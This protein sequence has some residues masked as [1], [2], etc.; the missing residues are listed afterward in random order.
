M[1]CA[2]EK[3]TFVFLDFH[4]LIFIFVEKHS[5]FKRSRFIQLKMKRTKQIIKG[6]IIIYTLG[7]FSYLIPKKKNSYAFVSFF[8]RKKFSGNLKSFLL[9]VHESHPEIETTYVGNNKDVVKEVEEHNIKTASRPLS[10]FWTVLRAEHVFIDASTFFFSVGR[11]SV[12]QLWH[13]TGFKNIALLNRNTKNIIR[14]YFKKATRKYRIVVC[15]SESDCKK[16][17]KSFETE[18]VV[19]TGLPRNDELFVDEKVE[20]E[21]LEKYKLE[22]YDKIITYAPTWRDFPT[23]Q[24]FSEEFWRKLNNYLV[25]N[26]SFFL[27]VKHPYSSFL[28]IPTAYSNIGDYTKVINDIQEILVVTDFLITDYS[29]VITDYAIM[30]KP[31]LIYAYDL[32]L[33]IENCRSFGYDLK[34]VLPN[35]ILKTEDELLEKLIDTSWKNSPEVIEEHEEFKN[36]FHKYCDGNSCERVMEEVLSL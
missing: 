27:V 29:S 32:E 21:L 18:N 15:T 20:N 33:Y 13:G 6:T 34:E 14:Y 5:H 28:K 8:D 12:V 35:P 1:F 19:A 7:F 2:C 10:L 30:D 23:K 31:F 17:G 25:Q 36:M 24:P 22:R 9:Y 16:K 11:F 26:N 4:F 3:I